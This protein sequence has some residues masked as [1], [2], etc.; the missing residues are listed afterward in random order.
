METRWI[1]LGNSLLMESVAGSS[2]ALSVYGPQLK[3]L[4]NLTQSDLGV[5]GSFGN[6]GSYSVLEAGFLFD[7]YGPAVTGIAGSVLSLLGYLGMWAAATGRLPGTAAMIS[8]V[9][10]CLTMF[11]WSITNAAALTLIRSFKNPD[12]IPTS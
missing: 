10:T 6:L 2:Y 8:A 9:L 5:I 1:A 3:S 4:L 11:C 12:L 7:A